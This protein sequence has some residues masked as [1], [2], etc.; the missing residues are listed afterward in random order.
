MG[1]RSIISVL[2][3]V[4]AFCC[5]CAPL[6][7]AVL[8]NAP[9]VGIPEGTPDNGFL[10][11]MFDTEVHSRAEEIRFN[12]EGF[13]YG[14]SLLGN[15]SVFPTGA[16]G[17]AMVKRDKQLWFRDV[18]YVTEKVNNHEWPKAARAL[19]EVCLSYELQLQEIDMD[20]PGWGPPESFEL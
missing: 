7:Q 1:I 16:L 12:R 19:A 9:R 17:E 14:P 10:L 20:V 3:P 15:A 18:G 8:S 4:W 13:L 2:I 5:T 11:P 6:E